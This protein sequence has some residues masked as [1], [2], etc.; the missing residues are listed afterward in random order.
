MRWSSVASQGILRPITIMITNTNDN[1]REIIRRTGQPAAAVS[2]R[3][4]F[5]GIG[6]AD[7]RQVVTLIRAGESPK[8][9]QGMAK[10]T[11]VKRM[12]QLLKAGFHVDCVYEAAPTGFALARELIA[13]GA[14]CL[15]CAPAR[16]NATAGAAK[17]TN[18]TRGN[19]PWIWR[20]IAPVAHFHSQGRAAPAAGPRARSVGRGAPPTAALGRGRHRGDQSPTRCGRATT[21]AAVPR[22]SAR[23]VRHSDVGSGAWFGSISISSFPEAPT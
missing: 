10:E 8:P 3:E 9:T 14:D 7:L 19:W 21:A 12:A 11:L 4:A 22:A 15:S 2:S 17:T 20:C 18:A 6:V 1:V 23:A 5:L 13:L 16:S